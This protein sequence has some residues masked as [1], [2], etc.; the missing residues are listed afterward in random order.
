MDK[1]NNQNKWQNYISWLNVLS[2]VAVVVLHANGS[3]WDYR[4]H[5]SWAI[6]NLV[7]CI[8]YFAV[9]IFFMLTGATLLDYSDKYDTK[10]FIKKRIKKT[11]VP[12][13]FWSLFIV[14]L[15]LIT[16]PKWFIENEL[17]FDKIF[18]GIFNTEYVLIFWFFIPLFCIYLSIPLFANIYK[19]KRIKLFKYL[20]F[21]AFVI[22]I[23]TPFLIKLAN[24]FF[25]WE[26]KWEL[27]ISVL[28]EYGFYVIIGYLLHHYFLSK[29]Q[30]YVIYIAASLG[31]I[32]HLFGTYYL[33][34]KDG[35]IS[36]YFKGYTN[37]PCV[38]YSVG[39]FVFVKNLVPKIKF[40]K[41]HNFIFQF[42]KYTFSIYLLHM[43]NFVPIS[44]ILSKLNIAETSQVF[45]VLMTAINIPT[46]ILIT[47]FLR[48]IPILKYI[49]P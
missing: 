13:L 32:I 17:K 45:V 36:Y 40:N 4:N 19:E 2:S 42:Q 14:T 30:R 35:V 28:N 29:K 44:L 37:L 34:Q 15:K 39:V 49:V 20:V 48:K 24:S 23:L 46:C 38:L 10:T 43:F 18:N 5:P 41:I 11:V 1:I 27:E 3:F 21:V 31:L 8:F 26:I 16:T 9:P 22:N 6:N 33:S 47:W 12:F 25:G 7:E